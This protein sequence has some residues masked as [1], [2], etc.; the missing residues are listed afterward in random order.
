MSEAKREFDIHIYRQCDMSAKKAAISLM[1]NRG[2]ELI[3]DV[4][5]EHF[6]KYDLIFKNDKGE[7]ISV[8]NEYRGNFKKIRDIYSTVHIPIRKRNSQCD[9]YFVWGLEYTEVGLIKMSDISKFTDKPVSVY[10]T[11]AFELYDADIYK[12]EFIDVPK[13]YVTFFRLNKQGYWKL[14]YGN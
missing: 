13:E 4:E 12:E 7:V 10:C 11:E 6:K 8:E 5:K 14:K 2:Y 3:G 1:K 9:Y